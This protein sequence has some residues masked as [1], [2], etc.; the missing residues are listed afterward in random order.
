MPQELTRAAWATPWVESSPPPPPSLIG[1]LRTSVTRPRCGDVSTPPVACRYLL[2]IRSSNAAKASP[3]TAR[4][5]RLARWPM[6][7]WTQ[8]MRRLARSCHI[9]SPPSSKRSSRDSSKASTGVAGVATRWRGMLVW[10]DLPPSLKTR[11]RRIAWTYSVVPRGVPSTKCP[12]WR[13]GAGSPVVAE[14]G[15]VLWRRAARRGGGTLSH[16][17]ARRAATWAGGRVCGRELSSAGEY[18]YDDHQESS[19]SPRRRGG[20]APLSKMS[21]SRD[22]PR[23]GCGGSRPKLPVL[24]Y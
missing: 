17:A 19:S 8:E 6:R 15:L 9:A 12:G 24:R 4:G 5:M 3:P 23:S 11:A 16:S 7:G 21:C 1:R 14:G 22:S 18:E 10:V 20:G 2:L 13:R